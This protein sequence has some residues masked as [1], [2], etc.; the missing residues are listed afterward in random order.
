MKFT[1]KRTRVV[2]VYIMCTFHIRYPN[3]TLVL[4]LVM[5]LT[6]LIICYDCIS[7]TGFINRSSRIVV[8]KPLKRS[9][10][11]KKTS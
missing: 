2:H 6:S 4:F 11:N 3:S 5:T 7:K 8:K 1:L 9:T 10:T